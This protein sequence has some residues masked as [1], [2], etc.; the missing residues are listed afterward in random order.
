MDYIMSALTGALIGSDLALYRG[1]DYGSSIALD[2]YELS[3][4]LD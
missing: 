4:F 2:E 3:R 1:S